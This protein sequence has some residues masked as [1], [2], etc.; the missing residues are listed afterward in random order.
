MDKVEKLASLRAYVKN[1]ENR[2]TA[3]VSGKHASHPKAYHA[4]LRLE[5]KKATRTID[6]LAIEVGS[7][8]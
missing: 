1:H 3:P 8:K 4:Y 5:I 7:G 6:K 2:L